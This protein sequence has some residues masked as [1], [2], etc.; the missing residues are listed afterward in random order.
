MTLPAPTQDE[1]AHLRRLTSA[2]PQRVKHIELIHH[3]SQNGTKSV[4]ILAQA[5]EKL[6]A[7]AWRALLGHR[8]Q[9]IAR[10]RAPPASPE[11]QP[12]QSNVEVYGHK[13][14]QKRVHPSPS[15]QPVEAD[16]QAPQ[17]YHKAHQAFLAVLNRI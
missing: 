8:V 17:A 2:C 5:T 3:T 16:V 4:I 13:G 11:S 6:S 9:D 14:R 15:A 1:L 12:V 7:R 10:R